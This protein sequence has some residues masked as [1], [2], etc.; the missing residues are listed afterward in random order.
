MFCTRRPHFGQSTLTS[1]SMHSLRT[2]L[3]GAAAA[4]LVLVGGLLAPPASDA[5][6]H[7]EAPLIADDPLADNTDV[8]AFRSPGDDGTVTLVANYIP[9]SHPDGG[10]NY[11]HFGEDIRYEIHVKNQTSAGARH[12]RRRRHL[13]VHVQP[14]QRRPDDVLQHPPRGKPE[15]VVHAREEHRRRQ[16]V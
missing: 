15:H 14:R 16:L 9:L 11:N 2:L 7:R 4:G 6:S 3:A 8:Y 5:S 12:G 1:R 10:P 13:P